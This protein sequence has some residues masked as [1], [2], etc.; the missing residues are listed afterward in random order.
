[1]LEVTTKAENSG[2]ER[3][4]KDDLIQKEISSM[5]F[6]SVAVGGGG[7]QTSRAGSETRLLR[8]ISYTR[9]RCQAES[10]DPLWVTDCR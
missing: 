6:V 2:V 5:M 7:G 9:A 4:F 10:N 1:M 8:F 3:D